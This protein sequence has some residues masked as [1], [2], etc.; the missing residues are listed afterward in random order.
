MN[1]MEVA[2]MAC[3]TIVGD[4][5]ATMANAPAEHRQR[6]GGYIISMKKG[7]RQISPCSRN[8]KEECSLI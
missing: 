5:T 8:D 4:N 1:L 2:P 7:L 3:T 6:Q